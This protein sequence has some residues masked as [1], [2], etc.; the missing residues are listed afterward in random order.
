MIPKLYKFLVSFPI[1]KVFDFLLLV[2]LFISLFA[3]IYFLW[4]N[5]PH[6]TVEFE[7]FQGNISDLPAKSVQFYSS[8]RYVEKNIPYLIS[9]NCSEKKQKD[10]ERAVQIIEDKSILRFYKSEKP[11]IIITCSNIAPE[12]EEEGHFVAGEGGP[13]TIINATNHAVILFGKIALYRPENC[14]RPQVAIHELLHALGFD[15]NNNTKSIMYPY[16]KCDQEIDVNI[17]EEIKELYS[18]P[19]LADLIIESIN[20]TKKGYYL[21][22]EVTVSNLGLKKIS[23]AE[24]TIT[25]DR[26]E[27]IKKFSLEEFDIGAKRKLSVQNLRIPRN[28]QKLKFT[29]NTPESEL[30]K[31]N[32]QVTISVA[33]SNL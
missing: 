31:E 24:L 1:M 8:M 27:E 5:L 7:T 15:H 19:S 30:S 12:P 2:I 25:D 3:G 26:M 6:E 22:F 14:D 4:L 17:L 32:N 29:I 9:Q 18:E 10:F 16:T 13:T 11:E 21:N 28:L 33:T 23:R 20:A